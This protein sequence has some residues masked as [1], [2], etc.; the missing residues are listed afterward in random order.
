MRRLLLCVMVAVG[1]SN[2]KG[3]SNADLAVA[4]ATDM[5]MTVGMPINAP[6]N[7][8]TWVDFPDSSCDDG[9]AT[10]IGINPGSGTGL[11]VFHNG[12]GACWDYNSCYTLH[13]AIG[14]PQGAAQFTPP[15]TPF[16]FDR[17]NAANPWPDFSY[18]FVPYCTGD[19]HAGTHDASYT[20]NGTTRTYHHQG[21][22]NVIAYLRRLV[23]TFPHP[24]K[25]VVT[26]A[27]AGGFGATFDYDLYRA[28]FPQAKGYLLDDS[29]PHLE[30]NSIPQTIR[31]SMFPNW[32]LS[33]TLTPVC[34]NCP[35]DLS[36]VFRMNIAGHGQ[37]RMA[38]ISYLQDMTIAQYFQQT[39]ASMQ[40]AV[41][42]LATDIFDPSTNFKY[43]Y[44]AGASHT[45][46]GATTPSQ[47]TMGVDLG[48]F[49]K[50]FITDDAAWVSV[51]P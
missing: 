23:A 41:L 19:L 40:A 10:G 50:R 20:G 45:T 8:W 27:S 17:N 47:T 3:A 6:M 39:P 9:S 46:L 34:P 18:V 49:V 42:Q 5:A 24:S 25:I 7:S 33:A 11:V 35:A 12:G 32:G 21:R 37:D 51:K 2:S 31:D 16:I 4:G 15:L 36:N 38:L 28:A 14:G 44:L 43:F 48:T 26:G 30:G 1:C 13:T 29:G 22:S